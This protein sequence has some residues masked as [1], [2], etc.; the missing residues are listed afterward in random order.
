MNLGIDFGST[1]SMLSF[2]DTQSDIIKAV[3]TE[4]GSSY[5]P[6]IACC[7]YDN[8]IITGQD[9]KD[10]LTGDPDTP[11]YRAFKMLLTESDQSRIAQMNYDSQYTPKRIAK[12]FLKQQITLAKT[13][14]QTD[15]F[16]KVVICIPQVWNTDIYTMSGK[17]ILQ[18]ICLELKAE[19]DILNKITVVSEPAAASAYFAYAHQKKTKKPYNERMLIVDYGGGTLDI[20]LTKVSSVVRKDGSTAMEI[21]VEGETGA[22]ENHG[23]QIG[24]AGIAYLEGTVRLALKEAGFEDV[25]YDDQFLRAVHLFE[26]TLIGKTTAIQEKIQIECGRKPARL[27]KE[28]GDE[29]LVTLRYRGKK[30]PVTYNLIYRS[31]QQIISPVLAAQLTKVQ[32]EYLDPIGK[33]PKDHVDELKLALVGGFGQFELVRQQVYD[34]FGIHRDFEVGSREDAICYGAALI[35]DGLVSLRKTAKLSMGLVT[36]QRGNKSFDFAI[37]KRMEL[38]YDKVYYMPNPIIFG[39]FYKESDKPT[40]EFAIG[41]GN[42]VNK[43]YCLVPRK[44]TQNELNKIEPERSYT[45]GFSVDDSDIYSIHVIPTN[46][47]GSIRYEKEGRKIRLGNF[48]DI[49]GPSVSYRETDAI[50][51]KSHH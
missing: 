38:E 20:S 49:F 27:L 39:G 26:S 42:E 30:I 37:T 22:G 40:W 4:H 7:N 46:E 1:Y 28:A 47:Q 50:F 9:A 29:T 32:K 10:F 17:A 11:A 31:Y 45:I 5:I 44:P 2:Y 8:K 6:S 41:R 48:S 13:R 3:Q 12:E 14:C 34:F 19:L 23:R 16:D 25:P 51:K 21:D 18:E 36:W 24:D 43:A 35:A 33:N 15:K